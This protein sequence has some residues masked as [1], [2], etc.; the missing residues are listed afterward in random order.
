M[1]SV[2]PAQG[3]F[4]DLGTPLSEVTFVV[5]DLETTGGSPTGSAITEIGAVK[6]RGGERLGEFATLVDPGR[7]IPPFISVLTGITQQMVVQAPRIETVLPSFLEFARG[8]VLVAHNAP[9]DTGFLRAACTACGYAWP[10][11]PV[12]DTVDLARRV[13]TRDEVPDCKL[14]TLARFFGAGTEPC[15]RALADAAA[16][17]DVLHGLIERL[18]SFGVHS[19]E[20]LRGFARTP[21]PEQRRKRHLAD[22]IPNAP[23]VYLFE[24]ERGEVLY[25][26][27][28]RDLR[29]RVRSYFTASETRW[30]V[31][32]MVGIAERV[33]PIVCATALEA[34]VRELR[35]I[36]EHK[37]RYNRRSR[38]PER[39]LWLKL[40]VEPFPRLSIVREC[41]DDGAD[42]LGPFSA[43]RTAEEARAALHEAVPL[44]QCTQPLTLRKISAGR[45]RVCALAEIGRCGAPCVG[46]ESA[47]EYARHVE[48]ARA[49]M[50]GDVLPVVTAAR[51]RIDR[52]ALELRYEEAAAQRDRLAAFLRGAARSQR[53]TALSGCAE[54]V[55]A[56]P[57]A[58]GGWELA[59]VRYGRLAATG[60]IPSGAHPR[61]YVDA[62]VAAA[63]T[64]FPGPGP[65]GSATAEEMECVLRWLDPPGARL[66]EVDG[67]WS[68]PAGGA[69]RWRTWIDRAY[70]DHVPGE[71]GR[72]ALR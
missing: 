33:R 35:L 50:S 60:T 8:C 7:E 28:S 54:F 20:E 47:Q 71:R 45:A 14:G 2:H 15:H 26:G 36:A 46:R 49:V 6:V 56:R 32:E 51:V 58:D 25:V 11:F 66:V 5:V 31:R 48:R 55:A 65:A 53:L 64:V 9:F 39:A 40:T 27:K 43:T 3:T 18:G 24:D 4:D 67:T 61:P 57:A 17:V 41:R 59:V 37:P 63:E 72:H 16:T 23:G 10:A 69:E 34:E 29:T 68:C 1:T 62:L 12:V 38:H 19:L 52:L 30:R 22:A 13:L 44:R 42:Y 21:T 70:A